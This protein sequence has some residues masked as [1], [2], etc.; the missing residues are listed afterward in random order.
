[1]RVCSAYGY[2]GHREFDICFGSDYPLFVDNYESSDFF[3]YR[4]YGIE[5]RLMRGS[6]ARIDLIGRI[7]NGTVAGYA[8]KLAL[9]LA[10]IAKSKLTNKEILYIPCKTN[11][12]VNGHNAT[13][14]KI[15][16]IL[17]QEINIDNVSCGYDDIEKRY[18]FIIR[19]DERD[20][21]II[22][23]LRKTH[24]VIMAGE[25]NGIF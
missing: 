23:Q 22:R 19:K 13:N 6:K 7:E 11:I 25:R 5:K 18:F 20:L 2:S 12:F 15:K 21:K 10:K 9:K 8:S 24:A 16:D 17:I 4:P 14:K 1:M 3:K